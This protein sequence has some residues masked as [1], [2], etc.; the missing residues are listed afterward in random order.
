MEV[1]FVRTK[2]ILGFALIVTGL[3]FV[4]AANAFADAT[5]TGAEWTAASGSNFAVGAENARANYY[6]AGS[7]QKALD[8]FTLYPQNDTTWYMT[9]KDDNAGGNGP[10]RFKFAPNPSSRPWPGG[11][12]G[13]AS[14]FPD[15]NFDDSGWD[16]IN[17]PDDWQVNWNADGTFKYDRIIYTNITYPWSGGNT[18]NGTV[19]SP[20]FSASMPFN[21][22]GTYRRHFALPANWSQASNTVTLNFDGCDTFYVWV[23]GHAVGYSEDAMTHRE[24]DITP[25]V[26]WNGADNVIAVQVIRWSVGS[27]FEDQDMIKISGIF[28]DI[29]LLARPKV[30]LYDFQVATAPSGTS[31]TGNWNLAVTGLLRDWAPVTAGR[32][33]AVV[34]A[35]LYNADGTPIPGASASATA[36]S[37]STITTGT[38][39]SYTGWQIGQ[40]FRNTSFDGS[41]VTLNLNDLA[42][43]PWSAEHPNLYKLVL[44]TAD[45]EYICV[46]VGFRAVTVASTGTT[47]A[48][49]LINGERIM[50]YGTNIHE[51]NPDDGRPMTLELIKKDLTMMKQFNINAIRMSH[52]PHDTRYYDL[53]DE[54]GLY[55]MDEANVECH[56]NTGLSN[57]ATY[58]PMLRDRQQQ[59]VERDKNYPCV[60]F[61]SNGNESSGGANFQSYCADWV[62]ARD[63]SRPL[64]NQF[65]GEGNSYAA[66]DMR[67][68]MYPTANSW[69]STCSATA[70]GKPCI[71]CE[72]IHA[73]G[74]S[75][76]DIY[77]YI[78]IFDNLQRSIG[79]YV[80]DWVDQAIW[81]PQP[82]DPTKKYLAFGGDWGDLP[83][84][85][86]FCANGLI[87]ADRAAKPQDLELKYQYQQLH[88]YVSGTPSA[89]Q[90]QYTVRN[91]YLFTNANE[92]DMS[93]NVT[94]NGVVI[95][96]G[97]APTSL[98]LAPLAPIAVG[99]ATPT[100]S[101]WTV[102]DVQTA[103]FDA[104]TPVVG[105]E[106]MFNVKFTL[107]NATEWAP[108]GYVTA[109]EQIPM[110]LAAAAGTQ[111]S[112]VPGDAMTVTGTTGNWTITGKNFKVAFTNGVM[113]QY[114][115]KGV[116]LITAG[117]TPSVFRAPTDNDLGNG[118]YSRLNALKNLTYTNGTMS[119]T[120][121]DLGNLVVI[122]V[123]CTNST[124]H[125]TDTN[126]YSIYSNGEIRVNVADSFSAAP[127][128]SG[129]LGEVGTMLTVAPGFENLTW[130]GRG[131]QESYVDRM[132]GAPAQITRTTV[133]DNF[134]KYIKTQET[135]NHVDTRWVALT[136][137]SGFGLMVKAG[138][139]AANTLFPA[140]ATPTTGISYNASN[141]I[142]F[143]ATHYTPI[144]IATPVP[145]GQSG[146][147][148]R[149]PY[150]Q[151][152]YQL[153]NTFGANDSSLPTT[154]RL[155]LGQ[156]GVGGDN[157]WGAWPL[158]VHCINIASGASFNYNYTIMPV[159]GL[160]D[161]TASQFYDEAR[162]ISANI[163]ALL[164]RA[165]VAGISTNAPEYVAAAAYKTSYT[166]EIAA[167]NAY[168]NLQALVDATDATIL[169]FSINGYSGVVDQNAQTILVTLPYGTA[170]VT[171]L[172]PAVTCA[173]AGFV[174]SP[175]GAANFTNPVKYT[176]ENNGLQK[177]YTVTVVV[178]D[179]YGSDITA[180]SLA[181][182]DGAIKGTNISVQ[183][184]MNVDLSQAYTPVVT[185]SLGAGYSP[186][187]AVTFTPGVP[188]SFTVKPANAAAPSK[189][190]TVTVTQKATLLSLVNASP[191]YAVYD[192]DGAAGLPKTVKANAADGLGVVDANVTWGS[193]AFTAYS[194]VTVTGTATYMGSDPIIF[195][196]KVEV[197]KPGTVYFINSGT[198]SYNGSGANVGS[199]VYDAVKTLQC[200]ALINQVSDQH[201]SG[202]GVWGFA[203]SASQ[204]WIV[205]GGASSSADK[206]GT[207]LY[208]TNNTINLSNYYR[209]ELPAGTYNI[210]IGQRDWWSN[211]NR[212]QTLV[213]TWNDGADHSQT[214]GSAIH[215]TNAGITTTGAFTLA[216]PCEVTLTFTTN[217]AQAQVVAWIELSNPQ[218]ADPNTLASVKDNTNYAMY[219]QDATAA[220]IIGKLPAAVTAATLGAGD[221]TCAVAWNTSAVPAQSKAYDTVTVSGVATSPTG[222]T[223]NVTSNIEVVPRGL[224]YFID[225]GSMVTPADTTRKQPGSQAWGSVSALVP[226]LLNG[227][228]ADQPF[229]G[230][231][232][233]T[234]AV[235]AVSNN[236]SAMHPAIDENTAYYKVPNFTDKYNTG[237]F[238]KSKLDNGADDADI[239]YNL[240]L[241]AGKYMLTSGTEEFWPNAGQTNTR[242]YRITIYDSAGNTLATVDNS[243]V[244]PAGQAYGNR[245][246]DTLFFTL[247]ADGVVT[248]SLITTRPEGG[249]TGNSA[250]GNQGQQVSWIAVAQQG[251]YVSNAGFTGAAS[252]VTFTGLV[253]NYTPVTDATAIEAVYNAAGQL[254]AV[255]NAALGVAAGSSAVITRTV[256]AAAAPGG[257]AGLFIWSASGY[258]P[259]TPAVKQRL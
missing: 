54:M 126:T 140:G 200:S 78:N 88:A 111:A 125:M 240:T 156:H 52:Y 95:R 31:Y 150:S 101:K 139:F 20:P 181:G 153:F 237:W 138:K 13:V 17:V 24:F 106:Y 246:T 47:N 152:P 113:T 3:L 210:A 58:G 89:T 234:T 222:K 160:T 184:P 137:N 258:V 255:Q 132:Y 239:R 40:G 48:T 65:D 206:W 45:G 149:S 217:Y 202:T 215:P 244:T 59:M 66:Y 8:D 115:Y 224:E 29:Y 221:V 100:G 242:P 49:I 208:G 69:S 135:G 226:G 107:K 90:V 238:S 80:W 87:L 243:L 143:N 44:Y 165:A 171:N 85:N 10:W 144:Q 30:D 198:Y 231:W 114:Q 55:V 16:H 163:T 195:T 53:A 122:T 250:D 148:T 96:S 230:G 103:A 218:L 41:R 72:Y 191:V 42:V 5:F 192:A 185:T 27:F 207:G 248:Y 252:S 35:A 225:C 228:S 141:L 19:T 168:N 94:E 179:G 199:D 82:N 124:T 159:D 216:S 43:L 190:Y 21:G 151:H 236:D 162:N 46:R 187:G 166:D 61:W 253:E 123:P 64:H 176:V 93:W 62:K 73:M 177:T 74:N 118:L 50:N 127:P 180:F 97:A 251:M 220:N 70:S 67:S 155:N 154:L 38:G 71:L 11:S 133:S 6:P 63:P 233:Y 209:F 28:R 235:N 102:S 4:P 77:S 112:A 109:Q 34:H 182:Y 232:G 68:Q 105:A 214:L 39:T 147:G 256:N 247:P 12:P 121:T 254:I 245:Q 79:G 120:K 212:T 131:P 201:S 136:D 172:T 23:N 188:V 205:Y 81:T 117:P 158:A 164:P 241:P 142:E 146:D 223:I 57:N 167:T 196:A 99:G 84:D 128:N 116:N 15:L 110:N 211:A 36:S 173:G 169:G 32:D 134:T 175:L 259:L 98:D 257:T 189:T 178:D 51:M 91:K 219:V 33:G 9:L 157:S 18:G 25:Y 203:G 193:A 1:R 108:A 174:V 75:N 83:D 86:N 56:A 145:S 22:V 161:G 104:I 76:G 130:Y 194:T 213:L 26:N 183:L 229:A 204:D 7:V 37:W 14:N 92:Y 249:G 129:S 186:A 60:I 119:M 2:I 197:I 227:N 170:S